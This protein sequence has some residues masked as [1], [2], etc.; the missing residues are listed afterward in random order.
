MT[1]NLVTI[2]LTIFIIAVVYILGAA[3]FNNQNKITSSTIVQQSSN[4]NVAS[5]ANV[6]TFTPAQVATHNTVS[7]CWQVVGG[8]V[9]DVTNFIPIHSGG[10]AQ[11]VPFCGKDA[12][13][14]FD[15]KGGRGSHRQGDLNI[16]ASYYVGDLSG[17]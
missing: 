3:V 2:S 10:A 14:A 8:K 9:Y 17:K 1:K 16:L 6:K 5:S 4:A 15:T 7:D 11:I 12:T 13:V